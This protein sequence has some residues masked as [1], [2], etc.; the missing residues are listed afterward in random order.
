M[1]AGAGVIIKTDKVHN[2]TISR[3]QISDAWRIIKPIDRRTVDDGV[4]SVIGDVNHA[5]ANSQGVRYKGDVV[6]VSCVTL[7][8]DKVMSCVYGRLGISGEI[9]GTIKKACVFTFC[10]TLPGDTISTIEC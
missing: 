7:R 9:Q 10:K 8:G 1:S 3:R 4:F 6:I 2:E 5:G